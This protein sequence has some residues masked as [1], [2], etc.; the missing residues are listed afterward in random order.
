MLGIST[1]LSHSWTLGWM[2]GKNWVT[3]GQ[4][5]ATLRLRKSGTAPHRTRVGYHTMSDYKFATHPVSTQ[6]L[7]PTNELYPVRQPLALVALLINLHTGTPENVGLLAA[8][9][10]PVGSPHV[11]SNVRL[12]CC[13]WCCV[14]LCLQRLLT[15]WGRPC[16]DRHTS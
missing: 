4:S 1:V 12:M 2:R 7:F 16:D 8:L 3:I 10:F 5:T 9:L 15:V 11:Y 13:A 14:S 6:H